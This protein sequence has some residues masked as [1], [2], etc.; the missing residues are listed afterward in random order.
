MIAVQD[1]P[2]ADALDLAMPLILMYLGP[3]PIESG[4][5]EDHGRLALLALHKLIVEAGT[6]APPSAAYEPHDGKFE[7]DPKGNAAALDLRH[8]LAALRSF[9]AWAAAGPAPAP[10]VPADLRSAAS[11]VASSTP[12]TAR[13]L[14][15]TAR[16][17]GYAS[18]AAAPRARKPAG[19]GC[20]CS[21][22]ASKG[23]CGCGGSCGGRDCGCAGGI[24]RAAP[25]ADLC[26]RPDSGQP[27]PPEKCT[28][29]SLSCEARNRIRACLRDLACDLMKCVEDFLC[30]R[31]GTTAAQRRTIFSQCITDLLCR[32]LA[33]VRE[34]LC[35]PPRPPAL[36]PGRPFEDCSFTWPCSYAV[37]DL[38]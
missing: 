13:A 35:P 23:G 20:G 5:K 32:T 16:T 31:T 37:E 10:A 6:L 29:W 26:V 4:G 14:R 27:P 21:S 34:A 33:C 24:P 12:M 25:P 11:R 8:A 9:A 2:L 28:P 22:G 30:A 15:M 38:R 19:G 3:I 7:V 1:D 36:P 17:T 18:A